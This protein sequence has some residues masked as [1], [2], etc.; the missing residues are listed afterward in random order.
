MRVLGT[1]PYQGVRTEI[2]LDSKQWRS[3][4]YRQKRFHVSAALAEDQEKLLQ[5][6]RE[7]CKRKMRPII[8]RHLRRLI[9]KK[10]TYEITYTDGSTKRERLSA[11]EYALKIGIDDIVYEIGEFE[12][13]WG[14]NQVDLKKKDFVLHFNVSLMTYGNA[15]RIGFV[16]AHEV[17]HIFERGHDRAFEAV[18]SKLYSGKRKH[19]NFWD[20]GVSR[21]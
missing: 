18:L 6:Y 21:V 13:E 8:E 7:F 1:V 16:V 20:R 17:A 14:I 9:N 10:I 2:V 12:S 3:F 5:A 19:E 11:R 4:R 15:E